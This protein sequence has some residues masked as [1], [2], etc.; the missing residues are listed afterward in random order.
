MTGAS[1]NFKAVKSAGHAVSH[2]SREVAPTY[3][4]PIDKS[5]G[6]MVLLDDK[7]KVSQVL[8]AKMALAS[9]R[10]KV[11]QR[12]SPVWEG[13]LNLRRPEA[14]EDA[15]K[16]RAECSAVVTDWYKRYEASTGHKVLRV[17]VHLD[18]GHMVDGEAVLNAHAHVIADRTNDLGRVIKLSPKQLR[19]LQTVTAQ[20]TGLERGKSSFETGRKHIGHQQYKALAEKGRLETQQQVG[21]VKGELDKSQSDLTRQRKLSKEWSNA[22][23]AK[24]K[25]LE[26]RLDRVTVLKDQYRAIRA[27]LKASGIATPAD[28]SKAKTAHELALAE[29]KST[30]EKVETMTSQIT[31]LEADKDQLAK[32]LAQAQRAAVLAENYQAEKAKGTPAHLIVPDPVPRTS[33]SIHHA[34][35]TPAPVIGPNERACL[36]A[37]EATRT[38]VERPKQPEVPIPSPTPAKSLVERLGDSMRAM[39]DWIKGVGVHVAIDTNI[40]QTHSGAVK[41]LD[42]LH[43]VQHKGQGRYAVHRL[44][45]LDKVPQLDDPKTSITY[46]GGKGTVEGK[47]G[48]GV[49]R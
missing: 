22:D 49:Q 46:R 20:V 31:Q 48:P 9:P 28:Y 18:E 30:K 36:R 26:K 42:D 12:Y 23:L 1:V 40:N 4:L 24:N 38:A 19:E 15:E 25:K 41:H 21:E 8:D 39:L 29:L 11:D 5:Y 45:D 3:L 2:A 13:I 6:T 43:T 16:Y 7:G 14:G 10:A 32:D 17:D 47:T 35:L 27:E 33:Q 37:L 34:D 44:A